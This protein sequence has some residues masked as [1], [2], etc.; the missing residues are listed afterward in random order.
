MRQLAL[1]LIAAF[2]T[3]GIGVSIDNVWRARHRIADAATEFI[4]N[5][6]D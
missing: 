3:F 6:Q 4:M 2:L 1:R 5:Y